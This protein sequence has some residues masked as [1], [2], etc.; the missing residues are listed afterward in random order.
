LQIHI[1]SEQ[2]IVVLPESESETSSKSTNQIESN[3]DQI[4]LQSIQLQMNRDDQNH[5]NLN[6]QSIDELNEQYIP[7]PITDDVNAKIMKIVKVLK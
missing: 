2:T 5:D 7:Q 1:S 3:H 6:E 4:E